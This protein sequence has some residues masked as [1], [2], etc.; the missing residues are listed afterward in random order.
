MAIRDTARR[1]L[2][3][4]DYLL[5]PEDGQRHELLDG[6]HFVTNAPSRWHQK[7]VSKLVYLFMDFLSREPL[8]EV[9]TGPF[10]VF[11]AEHDVALPD[12]VFVSR[13]RAGIL[14]DRNI[15]GA[16]DLIVE[17]LSPSTRQADELVKHG[18]YQRFGVREYWLADPRR[19]TVRVFRHTRG[20]FAP[21]VDLSAEDL[22]TTPLLPGLAIPV[23]Q[24]FQ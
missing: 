22:L 10:E 19:Q 6:E 11:F 8:G 15:Q 5:F 7:A 21:P 9:Y 24:I 2:T 4:D 13:E 23:R 14:T 16:P 1:K 17:V 18:I 3:Y 12:L 20:S